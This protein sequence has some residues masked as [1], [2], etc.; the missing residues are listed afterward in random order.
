MSNCTQAIARD[1][2]AEAMA[3]I[4]DHGLEIV[5]HVHDEVIIEAP[6]GKYTVDEVCKLMSENPA[7]CKDLPMSAAGYKGD[8]YFKD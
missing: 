1:I 7:W 6:K 5:A 3:R 2:L 8:Y 4:E